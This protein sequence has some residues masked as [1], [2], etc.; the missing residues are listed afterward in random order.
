MIKFNPEEASKM[1]D[2]YE[3]LENA[4]TSF[5]QLKITRS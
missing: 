2:I 3:L 1:E 5:P 4:E